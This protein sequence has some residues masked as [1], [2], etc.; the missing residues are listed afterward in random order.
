MIDT[1]TIVWPWESEFSRE[2]GIHNSIVQR[3]KGNF[4]NHHFKEITGTVSWKEKTSKAALFAS[5][6]MRR[7]V[8]FEQAARHPDL[9]LLHQGYVEPLEC[10]D[11]QCTTFGWNYAEIEKMSD[12]YLYNSTLSGLP[13]VVNVR[14][15]TPER[16]VPGKFKYV[17]VPD[18][19]GSASTSSRLLN[20]LGHC[21][22]VVLLVNSNLQFHF[23]G[24]LLPWVHYVPL[25]NSGADLAA[26]V[27]YLIEN[28]HIAEKISENGKFLYKFK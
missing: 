15:K 26:K 21:A 8:L 27:R 10:W 2:V 28:D 23:S 1:N 25:A 16:Y 9:F 3:F 7:V 17:V 12:E 4:S 18:G 19:M 24:K 11:P 20:V 13:R 6:D 14:S 5:P 22:C